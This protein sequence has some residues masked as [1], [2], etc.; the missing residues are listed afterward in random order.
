[1][2]STTTAIAAYESPESW[3]LEINICALLCTSTEGYTLNP[4]GPEEDDWV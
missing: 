3:I 1:M 2:K 4:D